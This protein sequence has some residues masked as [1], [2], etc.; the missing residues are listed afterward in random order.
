MKSQEFWNT[1]LT[2]HLSTVNPDLYQSYINTGEWPSF[3]SSI[4]KQAQTAYETRIAHYRGT[5]SDQKSAETFS[6]SDVMRQYIL[7]IGVD[8]DVMPEE[9]EEEM[10]SDY[11]EFLSDA[12]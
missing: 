3:Q 1:Q 4:S 2:T 7:P 6:E 5:G 9:P 10:D 12:I 11:L 8:V